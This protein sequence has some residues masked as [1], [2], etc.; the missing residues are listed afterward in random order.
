MSIKLCTPNTHYQAYASINP[1]GL[2]HALDE[3]RS[4]DPGST[5]GG[6]SDG[7]SPSLTL[8]QFAG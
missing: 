8:G 3:R 2:L 6:T 7:E 5:G 4:T 1:F